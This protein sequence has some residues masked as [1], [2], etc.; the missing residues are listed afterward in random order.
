MTTKQLNHQQAW[1]AKFLSEFNFKISYRSEKQREKLNV[2]TRRS[3]NLSKSIE[4]TQQ[5][6]QFQTL[7]QDHQL[8][9]DIKK[10]LTVAFCVNTINKTINKAINNVVD[11]GVD[12]TVKENEENKENKEIINVKTFSNKFSDHSFSTP[13]QQIISAPIGDGESEI[14]DTGKLLEKLLEELLEKAYKDNEMIKEIMDAK[15]CGLWKLPTALT[16]KDIRLSMGDLKI[17]SKQLYVKNKMYVPE[18]KPLQL[19]LLQQHHD[20]PIHDH[21]GYKAMYQ[22]IQEG[23]FWFDIAKPC[24]Q[25]ASNCLICRWIKAYTVQKQGL[26]NA[27]PI[28]N[29][30]WM[31]LSLDFVVKLPKY[32][33]RNRVFQY[34]LVVVDW[35]TKRCLYKPL[36]TLHTS[37]FIDVMYH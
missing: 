29:R 13:L 37:K 11:K 18:N 23:Y 33:Q 15:A 17:E 35:L 36:K 30:K 4:D 25:Y 24:K 32:R 21:T 5:Q 3:Q 34:I 16:K 28:S 10:A 9:K 19:F 14:D 8:D 2:L 1:W 22:K 12:K 6:H 7:L 20:P 27:L 31:D 26:L